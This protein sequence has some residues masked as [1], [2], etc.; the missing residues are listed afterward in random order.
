MIKN[1]KIILYFK[2]PDI[3]EIAKSDVS[4]GL[5]R[6]VLALLKLIVDSDELSR[7]IVEKGQICYDITPCIDHVAYD[8]YILNLI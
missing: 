7:I 3:N 2:I 6:S 4:M 8:R 5:G 1:N